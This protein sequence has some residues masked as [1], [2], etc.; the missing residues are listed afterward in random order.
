MESSLTG[1]KQNQEPQR[2]SWHSQSVVRFSKFG[3][4]EIYSIGK[5]HVQNQ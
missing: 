4:G 2:S 5:E 3:V 1:G